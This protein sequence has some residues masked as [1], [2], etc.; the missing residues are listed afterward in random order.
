[1]DL[2]RTGKRPD[3]LKRPRRD[4][5]WFQRIA[6]QTN[7]IVTPGNVITVIGFVVTLYGLWLLTKAQFGAAAITLLLGRLCD[8]ADGWVAHHTGTKSP[9]GELLDAGCDKIVT[10]LGLIALGMATI[11]P[12]WVLAM[13]AIP[14]IATSVVSGLALHGKHR[15]HPSPAGKV[16]MVAAWTGFAGLVFAAWVHSGMWHAFFLIVG[17]T[18]VTAAVILSSYALVH[19]VQQLN[20]KTTS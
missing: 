20:Q 13:V 17:Y 10:I 14:Q 5:S 15:L 11:A 16:S 8:V 18:S 19:Y 2:H 7:G 12:W 9:T 6:R 3:W 1:M 4:Y